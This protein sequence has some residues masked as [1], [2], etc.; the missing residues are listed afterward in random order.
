MKKVLILSPLGGTENGADIAM[1]HQMVYLNR[2]GYEV[3]LITAAPNTEA[4]S[5]FLKQNKIKHHLLDYTWWQADSLAS[6]Q[7]AI[8]NTRALSEILTIIS[9]EKIDVAI[10]NT[11]NVPQLAIAAAFCNI[12]HLWLVHEFPEG[13][14]DYT[15]EKY[16]FISAFSNEILTASDVLAETITKLSHQTPVHFFN[17]YTD[18]SKISLGQASKPRLV[19]VNTING[20]RKNTFELIKIFEQL[21]QDFPQLEL[22]ITGAIINEA[23]YE[24]LLDY[25]E[26]HKIQD[27]QFL[28]DYA[29]NW[30]YVNSSDIFVNTS[31]METFSLTIIESLKLG[32]ATVVADNYA[33]KS[34]LNLDYLATEDVYELGNIVDAVKKISDK[35]Y[36]FDQ[37]KEHAILIQ[38]QV[39]R[40]QSIEKITQSLV[41]AIEAYDR[42]P[43]AALRYF[44]QQ[45]IATG[46]ELDARMNVITRQQG[47]AEERLTIINQQSVILEERLALINSKDKLLEECNN[48][49]QEREAVLQER[50]DIITTQQQELVAIKSK[51]LFKIGRKLKLL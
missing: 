38:D 9:Q 43:Q 14:F 17:P 11:A 13:E 4:Y 7:D 44:K 27:I 35:L 12:P 10:T 39:I 19:S 2:L 32:V 26:A 33:V 20:T 47:I 29:S 5:E 40:E 37:A 23:Y 51:L 3:Q 30:Q 24:E 6:K 45:V 49:I 1:N 36:H 42:N 34:M 50:L 21:K 31:A 46:N 28:N 8:R 25:I 18:V 41:T 15:Y 48:L 22:V 16:D